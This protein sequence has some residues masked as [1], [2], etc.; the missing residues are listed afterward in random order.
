[1][2]TGKRSSKTAQFLMKETLLLRQK[3]I[4]E[5]LPIVEEIL[6][7]FPSLENYVNVSINMNNVYYKFMCYF[8]IHSLSQNL[9]VSPRRARNS[10]WLKV[11][12]VA[13]QNYT[14]R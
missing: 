6:T 11:G 10:F 12:R 9:Q 13:T 14:V 7:E 8:I 1:M 2:K 3:W 5:E 4:Q